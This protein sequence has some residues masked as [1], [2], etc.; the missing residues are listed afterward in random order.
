[1]I[2]YS[3]KNNKLF[4]I[5][6]FASEHISFLS[7]SVTENSNFFNINSY[8]LNSS[9]LTSYL[10]KAVAEIKP[11]KIYSNFKEDR[12]DIKKDQKDKTGVYCLVNLVNGNIYIGS[13][14]NLPVRMNN[15]LNNTYLKN[16]KNNNMPIVQALLGQ[17][18][19]AVLIVEYVNIENLSER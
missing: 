14:V 5:L 1:M 19:F 17:E 9:A 15:Y 16:R 6:V 13:S 10:G 8:L 7:T 4:I 3:P 18:N 12:Q 11:I 2:I